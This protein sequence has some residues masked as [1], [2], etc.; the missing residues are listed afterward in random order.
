MIAKIESREGIENID[1]I[2][3]VADGVMVA[4]RFRCRIPPEEIPLAQKLII[5][6]CNDKRHSCNHRN[7]NARFYDPQSQA[8]RA[9]IT[10]VAM[11][12]ST[13]L[14]PEVVR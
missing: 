2:I 6:K 12:F 10:D 3:A 4:R 1:E 11:Q 14:M 13:V 8:T 7:S 5:Q 9:E